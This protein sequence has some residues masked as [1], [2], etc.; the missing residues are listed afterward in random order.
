MADAARMERAVHPELAKRWV[1]TDDDGRSVLHDMGAAKLI[2]QTRRG[3]GSETPPEERLRKV[4]ILDLYGGMASVRV[5]SA[6]Y[7]DYM[8]L[9]RWN[10]EWKIVNVLWDFRPEPEERA[11]VD[12]ASD[13]PAARRLLE[14]IAAVE[15]GSS[16][17]IRAYVREAF[18]PELRRRLNEDRAVQWYMS[19][20]D[21][22]RGSTTRSRRAERPVEVRS[23]VYL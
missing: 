2:E 7:V 11:G 17:R 14:L 13:S 22:S 1:R 5:T 10:G 16:E 3:G 9:A 4:E 8:H 20:Y 18:A 12:M 6:R 19:L 15:S 23:R 21:R